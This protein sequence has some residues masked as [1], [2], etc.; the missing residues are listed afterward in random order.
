[1][2][3]T[4]TGI[5]TTSAHHELDLIV[6]ATGFDAITGGYDRIDVRGV[7]GQSLRDKW[8]DSPS[9]YVGMMSHGFPNLAMVAGP[10][11]ASGS[12]NFPRAIET[13]VNWITDLLRHAGEGG[14]SRFEATAEAEQVWVSEVE[15]AHERMLFKRSKGWFTGYNSNV[16]GHHAGTVR[17]QA[18]FGG[19]PRYSAV[20]A[21]AAQ[22]RYPSIEFQ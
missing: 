10:Q 7:D 1:M 16:E 11:S 3:L 22:E 21:K 14:M 4:A 6:Y 12:T 19:S 20:I 18:Y 15:R 8:R 5:E 9:T 17:Y 13:T 2:R